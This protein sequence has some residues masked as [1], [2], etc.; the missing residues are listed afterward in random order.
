MGF[1]KVA[2]F[3]KLFELYKLYMIAQTTEH[4]SLKHVMLFLVYMGWD[5]NFTFPEFMRAQ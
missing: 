5:D 1:G 4:V 2:A 3:C